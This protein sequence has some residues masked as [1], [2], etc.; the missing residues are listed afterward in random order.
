MNK[1]NRTAFFGVIA[2][3]SLFAAGCAGTH[4]GMGGTGMGAGAAV[5][6]L[7][8]PDLSFVSTAAGNDMY[9]IEVSRVAMGRTG[10]AQV[11]NYAQMLVN[12]HTMSSTELTAI[13]QRKGVAPPPNLPADKQARIAQLSRLQ[14][15]EFDREYIRISGIQ[16]HQTAIGIFDQAS[17]TLADADLRAFAAK[18]LPVLRQHLQ[19]AQNIAGTL[20]G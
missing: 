11:R 6:P 18:T 3:A 13:L 12:H 2:A 9:E 8:A 5:M 15:A 19:G 4:H 7:A 14:G 16:D 10:N 20:A 1:L 17:R